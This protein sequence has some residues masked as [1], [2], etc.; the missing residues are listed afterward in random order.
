V[1]RRR[2]WRIRRRVIATAVV[3]FALLWAVLFVQLATG[4]DPAL[5]KT[6]AS[7]GTSG[8]GTTAVS[9]GTTSGSGTSTSSGTTTT[10]GATT[11]VTTAQS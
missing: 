3:A 5:S 7:T 2:A 10:S 11:P 1:Y 4:H 8:S 9:S 6:K